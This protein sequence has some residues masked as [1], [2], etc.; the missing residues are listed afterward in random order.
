MK[1]VRM[2]SPR[3]WVGATTVLAVS[4]TALVAS[5]PSFHLAYRKPAL[6]TAL[7]TAACV[8]ALLAAF[9]VLG[10]LR[11]HPRMNELLLALALSLLAVSN[12]VFVL[13][14]VVGL[15]SRDDL[16]WDGR[17][18]TIGGALVLAVAALAP[19][20]VLD[21]PRRAQWLALTGLLSFVTLT[22]LL[23]SVAG[24][25]LP[26][27]TAFGVDAR[28]A[29]WPN[30]HQQPALF[31]MQVATGALFA[32]AASGFLRGAERRG[33]EFL[34]WLAAASVL[35]AV[36]RVNYALYP[37]RFTDWVYTGD[38]FRL[39]FY[40]TLLVGSM[41]EISFYW[42]EAA[43]AAVLEERRRIARDLHD[44]LAQEIAYIE[45]NLESIT[46]TADDRAVERVRRAIARAQIES[47]RTIRA[48]AP[49]APS[50]LHVA[51]TETLVEIAERM[52]VDVELDLAQDVRLS[53]ARSE[54]LMRIAGEALTNAARHS[55]VTRVGV[56]LEH[57]AARAL[58]CV[59]D[60]GCGFDPAVTDC[61]F[62]LISMRE[63]A[64]A[65]GGELRIVSALGHGTAVEV[66]V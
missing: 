62:G 24:Q 45:R 51:L 28:S 26:R 66:T 53:A 33:D 34:A 59:R 6:H 46:G 1:H 47:Q 17:I 29:A 18:G 25:R 36:S 55:G 15:G 16:A 39:L 35:A 11:R 4:A 30:L 44:G 9:L 14:A 42:R 58:L 61:G 38:G 60:A 3:G 12:I 54:A 56:T 40:I 2:S 23:V 10:R 43:E 7:E 48:L 49:R 50:D 31:G 52:C 65:V 57:R 37:T 27:G 20:Q 5:V 63:R 64:H 32:V 41:R 19:R 8:V 21:R 13:P 22:V